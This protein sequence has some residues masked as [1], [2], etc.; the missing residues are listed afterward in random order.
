[1]YSKYSFIDMLENKK[2]F[3][4]DYKIQVFL[5]KI[6]RNLKKYGTNRCNC[7]IVWDKRKYEK[8]PTKETTMVFG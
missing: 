7:R 3:K 2:Y 4:K 8:I 5:R 6:E 1:M